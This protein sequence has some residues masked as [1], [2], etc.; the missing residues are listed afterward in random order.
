M[1]FDS[2]DPRTRILLLHT[3]GTIQQPH[4]SM[5]APPRPKRLSPPE[6]PVRPYCHTPKRHASDLADVPEHPAEGTLPSN[7]PDASG[8]RCKLR[9]TPSGLELRSPAFPRSQSISP[10][11][12]RSTSR[13]GHHP[14]PLSPIR[15]RDQAPAN[16]FLDLRANL[17]F[18]F[19]SKTLRGSSSSPVLGRRAKDESQIAMNTL[20]YKGCFNAI[21]TL[22]TVFLTAP[23]PLMCT[24]APVPRLA[25]QMSKSVPIKKARPNPLEKQEADDKA[26]QSPHREQYKVYLFE[27]ILL[28]CKEINMNKPKNKML[29][30]TKPLVDKKGQPKLQL[31]GRIF[32]QNVTD[33]LTFKR[34]GE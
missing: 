21:F 25:T 8:K 10:P 18:I 7:L 15:N 5:P 9:L 26:L 29:G 27:R 4:R 34:V 33:V 16:P 14:E 19:S 2:L 24:P 6:S 28:C 31:K 1:I 11:K 3:I 13:N 12:A 22:E 32:M 30:N 17:A 20:E 23:M